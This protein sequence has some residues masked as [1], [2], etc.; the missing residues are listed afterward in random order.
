MGDL[1]PI[2]DFRHAQRV[3]TLM[4]TDSESMATFG[5][6][7]TT[8]TRH[9]AAEYADDASIS[10]EPAAWAG[11]LQALVDKGIYNV[12]DEM[13]DDARARDEFAHQRR[14]DAYTTSYTVI[15]NLTA[16]DPR[17]SGTVGLLMDL[18]STDVQRAFVPTFEDRE[19]SPFTGD[20]SSYSAS[21][22]YF[23]L[24]SAVAQHGLPQG[25]YALADLNRIGFLS[26]SGELR[27]PTGDISALSIASAADGAL[28][29][30]GI[31]TTAYRDY[32]EAGYSQVTPTV[33]VGQDEVA[34]R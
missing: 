13:F 24:E 26:D 10:R 25:D 18:S 7:A 5:T 34:P 8:Y 20:F 22:S 12:A 33:R 21:N 11:R 31:D 23:L 30:F 17:L 29:E 9:F 27:Y 28:Q 6:A 19:N 14:A 1:E 3:F 2:D 32:Y 4:A 16:L 15:R